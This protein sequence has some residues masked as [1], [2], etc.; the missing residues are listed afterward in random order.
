MDVYARLAIF[1][2]R[3]ESVNALI[4]EPDLSLLRRDPR[5]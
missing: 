3:L 5:D 1:R 4:T 2:S